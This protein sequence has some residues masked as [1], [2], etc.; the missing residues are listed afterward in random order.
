MGARKREK[1]GLKEE[2]KEDSREGV[3]DLELGEKEEGIGM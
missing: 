2:E 1:Q 3:S